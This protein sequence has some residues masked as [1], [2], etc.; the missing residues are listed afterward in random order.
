MRLRFYS[1]ALAVLMAVGALGLGVAVPAEARD[2]E[3]PW[4]Y[5]TYA[6]AAATGYALSKGRGTWALVGAGATLL[7]Y[8]QW[9][10]EM[11]KRHRRERSMRAYRSYRSQWQRNNR[12]RVAR[13]R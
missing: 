4:R 10:R 3:K 12:R 2:R 9:R 11:R 7:S 8:N 6:G 13:R 5:G 1:G